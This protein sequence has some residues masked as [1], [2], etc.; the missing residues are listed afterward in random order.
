M[1]Y[2]GTD[3]FCRAGKLQK[4]IVLDFRSKMSF[5]NG[6]LGFK[7]CSILI[8]MCF[9]EPVNFKSPLLLIFESFSPNI[10]VF[11]HVARVW[12][13][14]N[15]VNQSSNSWKMKNFIFMYSG[16]LYGEDLRSSWKSLK[17]W[18]YSQLFTHHFSA[19]LWINRS[20][21]HSLICLLL[22][23]LGCFALILPCHRSVQSR[24]DSKINPQNQ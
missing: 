6:G 2:S 23:F 18:H 12:V 3:V 9:A 1:Q 5:W 15:A 21:Y 22:P 16:E 10:R 11:A 7:Q 13:L 24:N 17:P 4:S 19:V 20:N 8:R 14:C